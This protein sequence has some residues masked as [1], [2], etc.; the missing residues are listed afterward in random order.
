MDSH[1]IRINYLYKIPVRNF[2]QLPLN[3][4]F[5]SIFLIERIDLFFN[6]LG[7]NEN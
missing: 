3:L 6:F 5:I 4:Y 2:K 1:T 7:I